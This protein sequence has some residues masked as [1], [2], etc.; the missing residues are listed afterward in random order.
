MPKT[1]LI[2]DDDPAMRDRV[3]ASLEAQG[4][5]T[6]GVGSGEEALPAAA[7]G[8]P[9]AILLDV[10]LPG[11]DGWET[12]RR[13]RDHGTTRAIPIVLLTAY[14]S[15]DDLLRGY[16]NGAAYYVAKPWSADELVRG[17]RLAITERPL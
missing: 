9:D 15:V 12:L 13:L 6:V 3:A 5:A 17:V 16:V 1:V 11:M 8:R 2:V 4:F 10:G 14:G 7:A